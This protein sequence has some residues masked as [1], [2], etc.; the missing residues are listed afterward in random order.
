[1]TTKRQKAPKSK[2]RSERLAAT[3]ATD[4]RKAFDQ[5]LDDAIFGVP[6]VKKPKKK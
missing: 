3:P 1:M 4:E 5:L 6:K 2:I